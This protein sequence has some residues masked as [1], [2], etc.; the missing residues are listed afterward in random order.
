M[1]RHPDRHFRHLQPLR[2]LAD[3]RAVQRDR[4]DDIV[5]RRPEPRDAPA[6]LIDLGA[7]LGD[8]ASRLGWMPPLRSTAIAEL[9]RGV[10]G[11]PA[12]WIAATRTGFLRLVGRLIRHT[13]PSS[14]ACPS[15]HLASDSRARCNLFLAVSSLTPTDSAIC[16]SSMPRA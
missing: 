8:F 14:A 12:A 15:T 2:R 16:L 4:A 6:F 11:D 1:Q 13:P 10:T 7:R 9:R 3:R 5:L